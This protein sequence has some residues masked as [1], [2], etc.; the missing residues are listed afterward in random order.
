MLFVCILPTHEFTLERMK[1]VESGYLVKISASWFLVSMA[2]TMKMPS[3]VEFWTREWNLWYLVAQCL[4][5]G[6]IWGNFILARQRAPWLSSQM[7]LFI[8]NGSF[9]FIRQAEATS[10]TSRC[11][12]TNRSRQDEE[13]AT[14]SL[15]TVL[16]EISVWSLLFQMMGQSATM[17]I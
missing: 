9:A 16:L 10:W 17:M 13:R 7:V 5:R 4:D 3:W 2:F 1:V 15:S 6:V 11:R 8:S 12:G 14:Y